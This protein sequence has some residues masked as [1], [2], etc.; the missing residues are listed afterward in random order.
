MANV[1]GERH[2]E[3]APVL[4]GTMDPSWFENAK[5]WE[6]TGNSGANIE[7]PDGMPVIYQVIG[8]EARPLQS[9][10]NGS[11]TK[12]DGTPR[13]RVSLWLK[14]LEPGYEGATRYLEQN[15]PDEVDHGAGVITAWATLSESL[16]ISLE[17]MANAGDLTS[18]VF[19]GR[20]GFGIHKVKKNQA[21]VVTG[22][23]ISQC[24]PAVY[25]RVKA[26]FAAAAAAAAT[27]DEDAEAAA[28][29]EAAEAAKA[30]KAKVT[31]TAKAPPPAKGSAVGSSL[32][33]RLK[34]KAAAAAK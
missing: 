23:E 13:I 19:M 20:E 17:D 1:K 21:G 18:D 2:V 11:I 27:P 26:E 15:V 12:P 34:A 29:A 16:Q 8:V 5:T 10:K 22:G 24:T 33:E 9:S 28:A 7:I 32:A 30:A 6:G 31:T 14:V 4:L 25:E 3:G